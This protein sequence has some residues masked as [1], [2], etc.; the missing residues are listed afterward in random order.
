[1]NKR[2][3]LDQLKG[4]GILAVV[5]GHIYVG[6]VAKGLYLWHMPLFFVL[7]GYLFQ[8]RAD[9]RAYLRG[10]A[11]HLLVPYFSFLVLLQGGAWLQAA[12][13][14]GITAFVK[15]VA[16]ALLGGRQLM[17]WGTVFWF[18]TCLFITQQVA[19]LLFARLGRRALWALMSALLVLAYATAPFTSGVRVPWNADV[20]LFAL[21]LFFIGWRFRGHTMGGNA[22]V[23]LFLALLAATGLVLVQLGWIRTLDLKQSDYGTPAAT[24]LFALA[25]VYTVMRLVQRIPEAS[26]VGRWLASAGQASMV[27]MF[28]HA[29]IHLALRDSTNANPHVRMLVATALP[30]LLFYLLRRYGP[31]RALFLGS[32]PDLIAM[33]RP[34]RKAMA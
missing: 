3:W 30:W 4:V 6:P 15:A 23:D 16:K 25:S 29:P 32:E 9:S 31:T 22:R 26:R 12:Q 19:N 2:P 18:I 28:L 17:G 24:L 34:A 21:P 10:K 8:P 11:L 27:I 5:A 7:S 13:T 33:F 1:M 14:D 20:V